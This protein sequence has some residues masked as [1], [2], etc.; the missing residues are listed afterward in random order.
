MNA[1]KFFRL[2]FLPRQAD[3]ALLLLRLW[4]GFS[5]MLLHGWGKLTGFNTMSENFMNFL[6]IGSKAS[7]ALAIFGEFFCSILL[8]LGLFTR[9][10]ALGGAITMSVAFFV[11]HQAALSGP[12]SGEMAFI[13]LAVY[14][15]LLLAGGGRF[16]LDAMWLE[17]VAAKAGKK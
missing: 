4:I 14:V 1:L 2:D 12:R 11:V 10:A 5:M 8:V 3:L 9:F 6:G 7:L 13:Y 16:S 15:A 17:K